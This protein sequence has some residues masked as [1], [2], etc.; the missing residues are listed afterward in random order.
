MLR[1]SV[2]IVIP[3]YNE[4]IALPAN[5]P[6][7][8]NYCQNN[9]GDYSWNIVIVDNA[10]LDKTSE[11]AKKFSLRP[12]ISYLRLEQKG[13]GLALRTAWLKSKADIVSY[14]DVDLSS[15]LEFFPALLAGL[16]NS[17]DIAIGS[18]LSR[19]SN[20]TGRTL[21]REVM[22][23]GYNFL[24]RVLFSTSFHDA[25]CGFKAVK[26]SVFQRLEPIVENNNW[27]FDSELL[28]VVEKAGYKIAEIP[29]SWHDDP[30]STV[31]VAGTAIED[32][33]GLW[34]LWRTKPWEETKARV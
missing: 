19:G 33:I 9:L 15:N 27:F 5:I 4:E 21:P 6:I 29:I 25:Q 3:V 24:I 7:L 32:L 12:Q 16:E 8:Y 26:K 17:A 14:M 2:D 28:I 23:R 18:R 31:K 10:S 34:R 22:S 30:S 1:T 20:V 11:I 13:R